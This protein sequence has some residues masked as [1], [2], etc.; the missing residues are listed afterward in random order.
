MT[1]VSAAAAAAYE[2]TDTDAAEFTAPPYSVMVAAEHA[3]AAAA[4][5]ASFPKNNGGS[6]PSNAE[7]ARRALL[8]KEEASG[9]I[10]V[11]PAAAAAATA[12][13]SSA[14]VAVEPAAT[15][16][17]ATPV[18]S[19]Q[20]K[21][22]ESRPTN[23]ELARRALLK[24]QEEAGETIAVEP[25]AAAAAV[26][27]VSSPQ[28]Q[29]KES[30]PTNAELARRALEGKAQEEAEPAAAAVTPI[31][32]TRRPSSP[33]PTLQSALPASR[34]DLAV[35]ARVC[36]EA[37]KLEGGKVGASAIAAAW[38]WCGPVPYARGVMDLLLENGALTFGL[39]E[40]NLQHPGVCRDS[41]RTSPNAALR[42]WPG[43]ASALARLGGRVLTP[44][45]SRCVSL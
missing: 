17:A 35:L 40:A 1:A 36:K 12:S 9:T 14:M 34:K 42:R 29:N 22:K 24:A 27:P 5:P 26:T 37:P 7:L 13:P 2:F 10:A 39:D 3:G 16:T 15:A 38:G 23:A 30:R 25:A 6:R 4:T 41:V 21:N 33:P 19:P 32:V 11:E 43:L 18:S 28:K 45:S 8:S 20:K 31:V 44:S